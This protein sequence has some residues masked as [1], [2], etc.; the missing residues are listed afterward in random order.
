MPETAPSKQCAVCGAEFH[1]REKEHEY[2]WELRS[3]CGEPC[4]IR[5]ELEH[6]YALH[7]THRTD[8]R[9]WYV[10]TTYNRRARPECRFVVVDAGKTKRL[11]S[12]EGK[13]GRITS[14]WN[15]SEGV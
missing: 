14:A 12:G 9:L 10:K 7:A 6:G 3:V 4:G 8:G 15:R 1:R 13:G 5:K 2:L 11:I